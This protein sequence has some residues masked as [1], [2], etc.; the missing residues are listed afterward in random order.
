M[1]VGITV[2]VEDHQAWEVVARKRRVRSWGRIS[3]GSE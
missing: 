2:A 3:V 1:L